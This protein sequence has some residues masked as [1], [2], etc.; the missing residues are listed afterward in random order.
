MTF[1]WWA[2]PKITGAFRESLHSNNQFII[3]IILSHQLGVRFKSEEEKK[4]VLS[5]YFLFS[6]IDNMIYDYDGPFIVGFCQMFDLL[7]HKPYCS[8]YY[9]FCLHLPGAYLFLV[10][11]PKFSV[12]SAIEHWILLLSINQW[13]IMWS[14]CDESQIKFHWE[15]FQKSHSMLAAM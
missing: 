4:D 2:S 11:C 10:T 9:N 8:F 15:T 6:C 13:L 7:A 1:L 3:I 12:R 5:P 14:P